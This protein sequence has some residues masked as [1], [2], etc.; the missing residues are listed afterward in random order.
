MTLTVL[1]LLCASIALGDTHPV[2]SSDWYKYG[3]PLG[4]NTYGSRCFKYVKA[5][6][7]WADSALNCM[8]LGGS[9]ASVHSL[10]EYKFIQALILETTGKLPSTWLGGYDAVVEGRWM[11]SDGSS[12]DYTNW[13]TG[14]PNDAGVGEDCLQMDASQ[15]KSW[16]DVP[17]KYAFAS[18]CSRRM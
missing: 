17:C 13:N 9:L 12:F 1:L 14:E 8:A 15:E 16:F 3:C 10:L 2:Q 7:S 4:W 5:K 6:R 11:W 18:L